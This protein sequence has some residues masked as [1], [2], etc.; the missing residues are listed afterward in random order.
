MPC[1]RVVGWAIAV[2]VVAA[3][4]NVASA[5][6]LDV[7]GWL[8][9]PGVKLLAVEFYATWCAPCMDAVPRWEEL[10]RKYAAEGLRLVVVS[11]RDPGGVCANPGWTPDDIVCDP[12]GVIADALGANSLPAAF[13]WSWQ[14][15]LLVR[16]GHIDEVDAAIQRWTNTTSRVLVQVERAKGSGMSRR[17]LLNLVRDEMSGEDKISVAATEKERGAMHKQLARVLDDPTYREGVCVGEELPPNSLLKA[18][19]GDGQRMPGHHPVRQ[20]LGETGV[21]RS[22]TSNRKGAEPPGLSE[23]TKNQRP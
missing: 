11:T 17:A 15:N 23:G 8:D 3:S 1:V 22:K 21:H 16:S 20:L 7:R 10:R 4:S 6:G 5:Q 9:R 14:G 18:G 13:L 12:K 19:V 2:A